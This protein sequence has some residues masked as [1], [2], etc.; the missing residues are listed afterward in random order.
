MHFDMAKFEKGEKKK[1]ELRLIYR[2][3][4]HE[5]GGRRSG[6]RLMKQ[7]DEERLRI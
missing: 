4:L 5:S 7:G 2:Q 6:G 3:F 1:G